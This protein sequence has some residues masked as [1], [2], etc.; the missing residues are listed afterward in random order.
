MIALTVASRN[1]S[2]LILLCE[3]QKEFVSPSFFLCDQCVCISVPGSALMLSQSP[4]E[5][6]PVGLLKMPT[7]V[8]RRALDVQGSS[9]T[10]TLPNKISGLLI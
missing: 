5:A 6:W 4:Q 8:S 1:K 7:K 3:L 10:V 9:P 2:S